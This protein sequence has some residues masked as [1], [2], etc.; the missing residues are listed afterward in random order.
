[1]LH[2]TVA[3]EFFPMQKFQDMRKFQFGTFSQNKKFQFG[4]N[5]FQKKTLGW[6]RRNH[7]ETVNL[8]LGV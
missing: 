8:D 4:I 2:H 1:M 7:Q 6:T 3:L 5:L